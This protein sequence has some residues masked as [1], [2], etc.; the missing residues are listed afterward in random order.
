[1]SAFG[2]LFALGPFSLRDCE[3]EARRERARTR[4][5]A[6]ASTSAPSPGVR[7]TSA[8]RRWRRSTHSESPATTMTSWVHREHEALQQHAAARGV[9][10]LRKERELEQGD[11]RIQ[12][13][14]EQPLPKQS[15][16]GLHRGAAT[17]ASALVARTPRPSRATR[18]RPRQPSARPRTRAEPRRAAP[19]SRTPPRAHGARIRSTCRRARRSPRRDPAPSVRETRY[20]MF[21]PGVAASATHARQNSSQVSSGIIG[22]A[23]LAAIDGIERLRHAARSP[24]P[25]PRRRRCTAPRRRASCRCLRNAPSS[26]TTIRAPDAPIGWPSAHAPPCTL[27]LSCGD[28]V[29]L[30]RRHRHDGERLVDLEQIDVASSSSRSS[31]TACGS[32]R[33]VPS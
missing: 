23:T 3:R 6:H 17:A 33:R 2:S 9:D 25:S 12:H 30:H 26:V 20:S 15:R 13:G 28:P 1:M 10:E 7:R 29:L 8:A 32:R 19:T 11:L 22:S 5:R 24:S 31:R 27:T 21:G 14:G 4:R 16:A 18:G